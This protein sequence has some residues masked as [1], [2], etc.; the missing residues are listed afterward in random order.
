MRREEALR[1]FPSG[2]AL[3]MLR[4]C[5]VRYVLFTPGAIRAWPELK[6]RIDAARALRFD[7]EIDGVVVYTLE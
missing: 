3:D 5:R 2:A 4:E 1:D 7:R 6:A